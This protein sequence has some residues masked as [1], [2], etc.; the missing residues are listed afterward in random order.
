MKKDTS[1]ESR[2][3]YTSSGFIS[4]SILRIGLLSVPVFVSWKMSVVMQSINIAKVARKSSLA[5][6]LEIGVVNQLVSAAVG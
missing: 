4:S 1:V 3:W 5:S 2:N 6:L